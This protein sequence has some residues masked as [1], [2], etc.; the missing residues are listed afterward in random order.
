MNPLTD[1]YRQLWDLIHS[2]AANA[3][4]PELKIEYYAWLRRII[5]TMHCPMCR[6][7]ATQY[8][9][10]Y[11]PENVPDPF[12]WSWEFHNNVNSRL[13]KPTVSYDDAANKY[14]GWSS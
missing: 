14:L 10:N 6:I 11:P 5:S 13:G 3:N 1:Y 8:I 12:Y 9:Q 2:K 7:H 4:T